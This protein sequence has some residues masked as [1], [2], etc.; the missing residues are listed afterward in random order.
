MSAPRSAGAGA[1]DGATG[2]IDAGAGT[3]NVIGDAFPWLLAIFLVFLVAGLIIT[4]VNLRLA[5]RAAA[6]GTRSIRQLTTLGLAFVVNVIVLLLAPI[7]EGMKRD[8]LTLIGIAVTAL[9]TLSSTT[10]V[11]NAMAGL[12]LRS[13]RN[14]RPGDWL[15]VGEQLGRVTERGLFHTEIQTEDRDLTTLPN[16][17]LVQNP[18][19]V[20]HASGTIVSAT[21]SLGYDVPH[22]VAERLMIEGAGAAGLTEPFV[23]ILELGDFSV[24]YRAAGFLP[25]VKQ[26]LS[27]RSRLRA[28]VLDA[29][30]A[31]GIEVLSPTYMCQRPV[32]AGRPVIP[33]REAQAEPASAPAPESVIFDKAEEAGRLEDLRTEREELASKLKAMGEKGAEGEIAHLREELRARLERLDERIER[34][35]AEATAQKK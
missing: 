17:Y 20:V 28:G 34:A 10:F 11:A 7:P 24:T 19:T 26:L 33:A 27:A 25:E 12:M 32:E 1:G 31:G 29:L 6:P 9:L 15:R 3:V 8:L 13:M 35:T 16:L 23:Q 21:V 30:H 4:L 18:V 14:F 5:R 22:G 2:A